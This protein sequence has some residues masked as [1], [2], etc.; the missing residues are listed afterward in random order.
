MSL[1]AKQDAFA[2]AYVANGGNA[3]RAAIEAGY[4]KKTATETGFENLRKPHIR[5]Y[6]DSLKKPVQESLGIDADYIR[7][8]LMLEAEREGEG[9]THSARI[10]ALELLGRDVGMFSDNSTDTGRM[11]IPPQVELV[12]EDARGDDTA[13]NEHAAMES[14][15]E[16]E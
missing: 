1:T 10:R 3:T 12:H 2:R 6:I 11:A 5:E 16:P 7:R 4:S 13:R 9:S 8:R 15:D 14:P